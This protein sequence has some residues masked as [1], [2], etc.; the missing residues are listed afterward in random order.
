MRLQHGAATLGSVAA[1]VTMWNMLV[2]DSLRCYDSV[3]ESLAS[4]SRR[5][6]GGARACLPAA[7]YTRPADVKLSAVARS[8]ALEWQRIAVQSARGTAAVSMLQRLARRGACAGK[9]QGAAAAA[10][11]CSRALSLCRQRGT[12]V[13]S[14]H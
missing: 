1:A 3:Q 12:P 14:P 8:H 6:E 13:S 10:A 11:S 7:E 2:P 5:Y 9:R 4:H